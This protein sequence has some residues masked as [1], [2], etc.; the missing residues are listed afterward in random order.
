MANVFVSY[1]TPDAALAERLASCMRDAGHDVWLDRWE[2]VVGDSIVEQINN[3]LS[4]MSYLLLCYSFAGNDTAWQSREWHPT[5]ARQLAGEP[6]KILPVRISGGAPPA[7]MRDVKYADL[8]D[9]WDGGVR[10]LL[11]AIR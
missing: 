6:V 9:D 2:I 4:S 10:D 3:G 1:R 8:C 5:L 11:A 7:I